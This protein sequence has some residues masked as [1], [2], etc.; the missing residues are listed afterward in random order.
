MSETGT[1]LKLGQEVPL[2]REL[3][4]YE[5]SKGDFGKFRMQDQIKNKR[6]TILFF[7]PADF[8]FV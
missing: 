3:T 6:W 2:D 7:Y 1:G 4:T 8:T 5:P